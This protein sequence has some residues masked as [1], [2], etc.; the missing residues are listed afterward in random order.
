MIPDIFTS[1]NVTAVK[2]LL[3]SGNGALRFYSFG[4]APQDVDYP[5]AVW[6]LVGGSPENYLSDTPDIDSSSI[7]ID[8]YAKTAGMA[9]S[10]TYEL[11][12]AIEKNAYVTFFHSESRDV[13]TNN[14]SFGFDCEWLT[15]R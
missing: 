7:Q 2:T 12:N 14:Y 6:Q 11:R 13:D 9:R 8:V 3:K 5:Y 10:V 15:P 1:V 4:M